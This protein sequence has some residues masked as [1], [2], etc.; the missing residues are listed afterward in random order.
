MC[1]AAQGGD[2]APGPMRFEKVRVIH[3]LRPMHVQDAAD[4]HTKFVTLR[5]E[6]EVERSAAAA[7][8]LHLE[9]SIKHLQAQNDAHV[10][11]AQHITSRHGDPGL[12][13]NL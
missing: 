13:G 6:T 4:A 3:E 5:R 12:S 11:R 7:H 2:P 8:V 1:E 10:A 9:T